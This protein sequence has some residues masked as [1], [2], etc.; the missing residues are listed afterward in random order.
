[1]GRLSWHSIV[2]TLAVLAVL[3]V[4]CRPALAGSE[5]LRGG[6]YFLPVYSHIYIGDRARPFLLAITVSVRNTSLT[7]PMTLTAADFYD[8]D[9]TLLNRYIDAPKTIEPFGSM[10]LTVAES[11]KHGGAGAKFLVAWT[12][13]TPMTPPHVEAVMIGS[14]G[15][16]GISFT[17]QAVPLKVER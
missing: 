10:R 2:R 4:F 5:L 9:G 14:G 11:E 15:Q 3:S 17:S 16:Q 6:T 8:S 12:A 7:E 1:M 13:R